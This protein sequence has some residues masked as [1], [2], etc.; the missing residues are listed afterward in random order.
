MRP[1][2][3]DRHLPKAMYHRHGAYYHVVQG[4]WHRLGENYRD[5]LNA[6]A[7]RVDTGGSLGALI[8][9]AMAVADI[10]ESTLKQYQLIA[11]RLKSAFAE[12]RPEDVKPVDVQRF[13]NFHKA[14][15]HMANRMRSLL[16]VTFT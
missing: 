4:K 5:A 10:A 11:K 6:Y 3:T 2:K 8:D 9:K 16:M 15:P 7:L 14:K 13:M 1:R 12:Y